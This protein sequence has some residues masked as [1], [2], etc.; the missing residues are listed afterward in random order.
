V[1]D[2]ALHPWNEGSRMDLRN[3]CEI[4][5]KTK[6]FPESFLRNTRDIPKNGGAKLE[7]WKKMGIFAL[8]KWKFSATKP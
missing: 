3:L 7:K 2:A 4:F 8:E 5:P 1:A 6:P